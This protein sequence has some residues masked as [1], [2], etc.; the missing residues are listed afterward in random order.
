MTKKRRNILTFEKRKN[1]DIEIIYRDASKIIFTKC[2][3][4]T[5]TKG[6]I[7]LNKRHV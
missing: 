5:N 6:L 1:G 4:S 3:L 7:G 2:R